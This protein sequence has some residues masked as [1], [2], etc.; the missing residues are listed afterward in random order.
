M[1]TPFQAKEL[2]ASYSEVPQ[3]PHPAMCFG[4]PARTF[5]EFSLKKKITCMQSTIIYQLS[6]DV[7]LR[8]PSRL[9]FIGLSSRSEGG[10]ALSADRKASVRLGLSNIEDR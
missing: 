4:V 7:T 1:G 3:P 5:Q 10:P 8:T 9:V 2:A 6:F